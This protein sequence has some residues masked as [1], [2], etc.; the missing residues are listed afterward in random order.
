MILQHTFWL[1]KCADFSRFSIFCFPPC[2]RPLNVRFGSKIDM[3]IFLQTLSFSKVPITCYLTHYNLPKIGKENGSSAAK[4]PPSMF[5]FGLYT[6]CVCVS[7]CVCERERERFR[8]S[9]TD[10]I[11]LTFLST[12]VYTDQCSCK[13]NFGLQNFLFVH[14]CKNNLMAKEDAFCTHV[15]VYKQLVRS[16]LVTSMEGNL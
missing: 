15:F 4:W 1:R 14:A 9:S 5:C 8:L 6:V 12:C 13:N 16:T 7:V 11:S 2:L 3:R 10:Q